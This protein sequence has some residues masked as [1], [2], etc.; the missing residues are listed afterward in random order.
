TTRDEWRHVGFVV[1]V[2]SFGGMLLGSVVGGVLGERWYTKVS[3]RV[4]VAEAG[5]IDVRERSE[6]GASNGHVARNGRNGNGSRRSTTAA[7]P[8]ID[9]LSKEEL[10]TRAQEE[11]IPGRSHMSKDELKK[12]L[13][14]HG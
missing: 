1:S 9:E 13:Q 2:A 3:R 11:D 4:L 5:E 10:Y 8:D 12:A 14:K 7:A 6:A